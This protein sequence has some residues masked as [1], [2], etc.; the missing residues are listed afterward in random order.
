MSRTA[1]L[2]ELRRRAQA[3]ENRPGPLAQA[4]HRELSQRIGVLEA[5][6]GDTLEDVRRSM[7]DGADRLG[8]KRNVM[9]LASAALFT[10]LAVS[11]TVTGGPAPGGWLQGLNFVG[12]MGGATTGFLAVGQHE[13]RKA[14]L[15]QAGELSDLALGAPPLPH[16]DFLVPGGHGDFGSMTRLKGV[17][18]A[19]ES[20]LKGLGARPEVEAALD[21]LAR[22]RK[23]VDRFPAATLEESRA[24][25]RTA[26]DS[27]QRAASRLDRLVRPGLLVGLGG[28]LGSGLLPGL[29]PVGI[30]VLAVSLVAA[31]LDIWHRVRAHD[32]RQ[33]QAALGRWQEQL[34]ELYRM[35]EGARDD[36]E[37]LAS[38]PAGGGVAT[39]SGYVV[40][41]GVRVPVL[42][43][44]A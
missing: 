9:L 33:S 11:L 17:L 31:G 29:L 2:D 34:E 6:G 42:E 13:N 35:T 32:A 21:Q 30:G 19:T 37:R 8:R 28:V 7:L 39:R 27:E 36:V 15:R 12:L 43:R 24:L 44:R 26:E 41:G 5:W 22:D 14:L 23:D 18:Q 25:A 4:A 10:T 38:E 1:A 3:C 20:S 16:T 40:V